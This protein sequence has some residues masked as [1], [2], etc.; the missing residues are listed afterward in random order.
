MVTLGP[1]PRQAETKK[2]I[3]TG[4]NERK[5]WRALGVNS[6]IGSFTNSL[7]KSLPRFHSSSLSSSTPKDGFLSK[8]FW[9]AGLQ[10]TPEAPKPR[11]LFDRLGGEE[12][13][14]S[15][16]NLLYDKIGADDRLAELFSQ[17]NLHNLQCKQKMFFTM[18][19][20]GPAEYDGQGISR[21][22]RPLVENLGLSEFHFDIFV[23]HVKSTLQE[24]KI[25]DQN[26]RQV[27][28]AVDKWKDCVLCCNDWA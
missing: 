22:H 16:V 28:D 6:V 11:S 1:S 8:G 24:L 21:M 13:I 18:I 7:P 19:C 5:N 4:N 14:I 26:T 23:S 17:V 9:I 15:I 2:D 3:G 10:I 20:E 12:T 27:V 25:N